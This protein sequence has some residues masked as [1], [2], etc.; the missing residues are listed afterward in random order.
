[1][2]PE[3]LK[4]RSFRQHQGNFIHKEILI[5]SILDSKWKARK[6]TYNLSLPL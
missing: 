3:P 4:A 1:M 2:Q 6:Q 5:N